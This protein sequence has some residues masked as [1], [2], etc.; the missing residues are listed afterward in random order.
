MPKPALHRLTGILLLSGGLLFSATTAQLAGL[1]QLEA[2]GQ[3]EA[4][5]SGLEQLAEASPADAEILWRIAQAHFD[6]ADQTDNAEEDKAHL[7]PGLEA[8]GAALAADSTSARA[9][10]WYAVLMGQVGMLEGTRQKITNSYAVRKYALRAIELDPNY[11]G[12]YHVMGRWHYEL[13][14]L[15][16]FEKKIAA[17]VYGKLP[18]GSFA[19]AESYFH[20]AMKAKPDETRHYLWLGKTLME[21]DKDSEAR[22]ILQDAL[23]LPPVSDSDRRLQKEAGELLEDL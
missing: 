16:W 11:D 15:N 3:Y 2:D 12:T 21:E 22:L 6:I 7:Y 14:S 17:L 10:H 20:K 13:A 8:A 18:E 4:T 19:E 9:N 1:D 5:L 23:A